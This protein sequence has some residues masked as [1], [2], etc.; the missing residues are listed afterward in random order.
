M[1]SIKHIVQCEVEAVIQS[2]INIEPFQDKK[3]LNWRFKIINATAYYICKFGQIQE[4]NIKN[5]FFKT[6]IRV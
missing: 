4:F 5:R 6:K 1:N 3:I 2:I